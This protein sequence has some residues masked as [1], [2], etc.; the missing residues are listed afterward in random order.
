MKTLIKRACF[1][2]K[3]ILILFLISFSF[4]KDTET[5]SG[6]VSFGLMSEK[7]PATFLEF[8]GYSVLNDNTEIFATFSYIVFGGGIGIGAKYYL[9]DRKK[10]SLFIIGGFSASVLGDAAESYVGPHISTGISISFVEILN[11]MGFDDI[12]NIAINLGAGHVFYDDVEF[13]NEKER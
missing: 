13:N 8:T 12:F 7:I 3:Y 9:R 10:T 5:I 4:T 6:S 11:R 2:R 1:N